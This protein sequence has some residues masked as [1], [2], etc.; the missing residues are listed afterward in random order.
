MRITKLQRWRKLVN[1]TEQDAADALDITLNRYRSY[2]APSFSPNEKIPNGIWLA[3]AAIALGLKPIPITLKDWRELNGM[4]MQEVAD[5][6]GQ[7]LTTYMKYEAADHGPKKA[8]EG[9]E[10]MLLA[11]AAYTRGIAYYRGPD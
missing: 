9:Q 4:S 2:E 8:S 7:S 11:C 5:L 6:L 1:L 3:C 10:W